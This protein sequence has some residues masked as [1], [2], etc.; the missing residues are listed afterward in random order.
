[1]AQHADIV[2]PSTTAF[3]R[4]D[5]SGSR[6]DPLLMAMP[7]LTEPYAQ[8]RDDYRP[9]PR[10]RDRL[11]FGEQFTEGRTARRVAGHMYEKWSAELDFAV[12]TFDEFWA[13]RP[14]AAAGRGPA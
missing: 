8:S 12:P 2:V 14:A 6:N 1:M 4:D 9:S 11:G 3:E 7:A 13:D 5:Y 10:W